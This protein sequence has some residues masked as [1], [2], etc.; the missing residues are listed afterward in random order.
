MDRR[1]FL[2]AFAATT[3]SS[4]VSV[5]GMAGPPVPPPAFRVGD[6]WVYNARDGFRVAVTWEET[7]EVTA[8]S[9]AG[10]DVRVVLRGDTMNAVRMEHLLA[11][12]MVASG[13]VFNPEET[14][15][16]VPP[17]ER[18]RFPLTFGDRWTQN[19]QNFNPANGLQS[20]INR[21]VEVGGYEQV[22]TPAGTFSAVRMR[23]L[24]SVDE[25]NPFRWPFQ[26][27][28]LTWWAPDVGAMVKEIKTATY[29][30]RGDGRE[31]IDI[32]A[33]NTTVEL[34]S[35]SRGG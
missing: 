8:V 27:N 4:C 21:F 26:C 14:R 35:F 15:N 9:P 23:T 11:A 24:M 30:E 10:I 6:R 1:T 16:F 5:G 7:H 32:R 3:L 19:M 33:Q 28:Y 22:T 12:G 2:G 13:A 25:N 29:R 18:Y 20:Q 34:A 17:M 31:G